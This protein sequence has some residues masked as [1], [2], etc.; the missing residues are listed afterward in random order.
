MINKSLLHNWYM[1]ETSSNIYSGQF[2]INYL[3]ILLRKLVTA[4]ALIVVL[5]NC[6]IQ[7][8]K[9][10]ITS[11]LTSLQQSIIGGKFRERKLN[12][13]CIRIVNWNVVIPNLC[14]DSPYNAQFSSYRPT[15]IFS[16]TD[17]HDQIIYIYIDRIKKARR[18]N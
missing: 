12:T 14:L 18:Y 17:R 15:N 11:S 16:L 6:W 9:V 3:L 4:I 1:L 2:T 13:Q 7:H 8:V 5:Y 10:Y